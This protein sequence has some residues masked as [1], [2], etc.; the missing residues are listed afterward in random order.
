MRALLLAIALL[1]PLEQMDLEVQRAVQA[2]RAPWLEP[3]MRAASGV[4]RPAN[5][6]GALLAI[7]LFDATAGPATAR[8]ALA[9]LLPTNLVVEGLKLAVD[10]PR[11]DG[12]HK[13]SNASFPSSHAANAAAIAWIFSRRWRRLAPAFWAAALLVAWSRI[14]L[15]RHYLSDVLAGLAI[16]MTCAWLAPRIGRRWGAAPPAPGGASAE[17]G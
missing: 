3:V 11:P 7:A 8:L 4:G 5:V 12:E 10:R 2:S 16:G 14:Y 17:S 13:R 6:L 1:A 15:D 9:A